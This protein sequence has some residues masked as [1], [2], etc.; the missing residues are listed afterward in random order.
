MFSALL[1]KIIFCI[2]RTLQNST[3]TIL[4]LTE[5]VVSNLLETLD[6]FLED[7]FYCE[8]IPFVSIYQITAVSKRYELFLL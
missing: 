5:N 7:E 3:D 4:W 1:V 2:S 8:M 6:T